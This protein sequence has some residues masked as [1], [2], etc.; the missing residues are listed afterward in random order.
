M[1][2]LEKRSLGISKK[3]LLRWGSGMK[4]LTKKID[5]K[6][7]KNGKGVKFCQIWFKVGKQMKA[8]FCVCLSACFL[9]CAVFCF[10][11][12]E[13]ARLLVLMRQHSKA[14]KSTVSRVR[15]LGFKPGLCH[16]PAEGLWV[17][18]FNSLCLIFLTHKRR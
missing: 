3:E 4:E 16:L 18:Y 1:E 6:S 10:C 13:C 11:C 14:T 12:L 8:C 5:D 15:Q 9:S 7:R 17:S 2:G